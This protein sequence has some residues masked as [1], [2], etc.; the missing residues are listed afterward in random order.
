MQHAASGIFFDVLSIGRSPIITFYD[1]SELSHSAGTFC[2]LS[3]TGSPAKKN[4]GLQ[5]LGSLCASALPAA[6]AAN[7]IL[8]IYREIDEFC[9][10]L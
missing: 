8:F 5:S 4:P 7:D 1:L 3:E 6:V 2:I 10:E 9:L